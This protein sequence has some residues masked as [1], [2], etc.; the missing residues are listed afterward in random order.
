LHGSKACDLRVSLSRWE[1]F[2]SF[3]L[4]LLK[5]PKFGNIT[6]SVRASHDKSVFEE[7]KVT[8]TPSRTECYIKSK[9][10]KQFE[11]IFTLDRPAE[12][13][14]PTCS[15]ACYLKVD[16][17]L[18]KSRILGK[19]DE[20]YY[21]SAEIKGAQV[22]RTEVRPFYFGATKFLGIQPRAMTGGN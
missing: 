2:P 15:Y 13:V 3:P 18:V 7:H 20:N 9:V 21:Q 12:P 4:H 17:Q 10:G 1:K 8:T 5:M 22:S 6:V 14:N 16:G 11:V 19:V